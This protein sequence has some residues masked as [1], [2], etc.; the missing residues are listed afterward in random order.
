M[1]GLKHTSKI[2]D[3]RLGRKLST[4]L[5]SL[6]TKLIKTPVSIR[7]HHSHT[8]QPKEVKSFLEKR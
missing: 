1:L 5:N 4:P 6:G 7:H 2:V 8:D 3:N